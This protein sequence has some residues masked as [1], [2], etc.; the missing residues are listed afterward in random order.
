MRR[1]ADSIS[2]EI[3]EALNKAGEPLE[4]KEVELILKDVTRTKILYRLNRLRGDGLIKGKPVGSGKGT[5][6]WWKK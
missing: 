1:I 3:I 6:I 5:W 2:D 4:T